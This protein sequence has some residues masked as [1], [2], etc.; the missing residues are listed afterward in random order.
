MIESALIKYLNA[1]LS[2]EVY[3]YPAP[4]NSPVPVI[5]VDNQGTARSRTHGQNGTPETG[6]IEDDF[7]VT[8]WATSRVA[9]DKLRDAIIVLL[10]SYRG[11]MSDNSSPVRHHVVS[12]IK[13]VDTDQDFNTVERRHGS[14]V[15]LTV[16]HQ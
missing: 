12:D 1:Q 3:P 8:V 11:R 7:E 9:A 13:I 15:F 5:S 4:A 10:E 16:S 14:T 6:M 2:V